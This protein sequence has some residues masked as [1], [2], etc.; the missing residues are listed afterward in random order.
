MAEQTKIIKRVTEFSLRPGPRYKNQGSFSG[1]EFYNNFLKDWF[2]VALKTNSILHV[3]LDGTDGYLTS[4]IDESFGRLIY[5][6][7]RASVEKHLKIV[8]ELEP[9][10]ISRLNNKTYP[11]WEQ[12][13]INHEAPI[14]T[15]VL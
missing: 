10:W 5:D 2:E 7:G 8:S 11:F 12:R 4:F 15:E 14:T 6:F 1:E 9:E 13:R 3:V